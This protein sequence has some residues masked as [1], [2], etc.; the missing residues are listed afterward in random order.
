M[1]KQDVP[2]FSLVKP[3]LD[4]LTNEGL[5]LCSLDPQGKPNAMAIGWGVLGCVWGRPVFEVLVRHSRYTYECIE[6][7][8]DF[9]VNVMPAELSDVVTYFGSVSGRDVDKFAEKG[10]SVTPAKHTKAP[11]I[12]QAVIVYECK[13]LH[14]NEV[15]P[16][17]LDDAIKPEFYPE[18]DYHRIYF[19][20]IL[21]VYAE[22]DA[23]QRVTQKSQW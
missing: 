12:E 8:G 19:G 7:T 4:V 21:A 5:L 2:L 15:I 23:A 20:E 17:R 22:P 3:T 11:A 1:A 14:H 6:A 13:V 9:T 18:G 10:L 16:E